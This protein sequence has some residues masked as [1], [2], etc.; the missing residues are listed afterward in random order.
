MFF[1]N[2]L[3]GKEPEHLMPFGNKR[4]NVENEGTRLK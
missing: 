4:V 3:N 2:G 1:K